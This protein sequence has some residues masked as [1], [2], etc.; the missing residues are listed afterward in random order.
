MGRDECFGNEEA[1]KQNT[2]P[3]HSSSMSGN[4]PQE[5]LAYYYIAQPTETSNFFS[6]F[7]TE[8]P[9]KVEIGEEETA[10]T[11]LRVFFFKFSVASLFSTSASRKSD[12]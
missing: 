8:K 12:V 9:H 5:L 3:I 11:T 2:R 4:Y 7:S 10:I 1:E 6:G